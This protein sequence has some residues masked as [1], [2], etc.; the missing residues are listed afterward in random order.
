MKAIKS[1]L[2]DFSDI[3]YENLSKIFRLTLQPQQRPRTPEILLSDFLAYGHGG[4]CF[5]LNYAIIKALRLNGYM[6]WPVSVQTERNSFPHYAIIF[7]LRN[8]QYLI[9][10]GYLLYSPLWLKDKGSDYGT[11]GVLDYELSKKDGIYTLYSLDNKTRK[12]R[13]SFIP[14]PVEDSIFVR[15]WICS[16]DYMSAVVASRIVEERILYINDDYV[17]F[18]DAHSVQKSYDRN[19]ADYYLSTYFSYSQE[20]ILKARDL[21]KKN[22]R[23]QEE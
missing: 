8:Q 18:T 1:L 13:Y 23:L 15:H 7:T 21:V 19:K 5:S 22:S 17:R 20:D 11:N 10:P 4:T 9:D 16:F 2:N 12:K 6:A 14:N 3:P